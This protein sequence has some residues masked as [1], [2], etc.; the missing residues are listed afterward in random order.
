M[1]DLERRAFQ[2]RVDLPALRRELAAAGAEADRRSAE[3]EAFDAVGA[4][5][6]LRLA[7]FALLWML[8]IALGL[9]GAAS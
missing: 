1:T 9:L 5:R 2:A 6:A 7:A 3:L 4:A 8:P